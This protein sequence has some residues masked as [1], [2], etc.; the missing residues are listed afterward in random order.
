MN[1]PKKNFIYNLIYQVLVLIIPLITAP[2]LARVVG[3]KG[4]GTYSYTYSIVYYFMLLTL[5]GVNNYGN[6]SI[7]KVRDNKKKLSKTFW[8]I[9][10]FQLLMGIIML[11]A[12]IGYICLFDI[13]YKNIAILQTL[14]VLSAILD[15]NWFFF[16]MEEF[17]KTITRNTFVKVGNILLIFLLVKGKNDL[18]K[19]TLIMSGMTCLSQVI[20]WGFLRKQII[21]V[22]VKK[23]DIIKHIKPNLILFIPVVAVSLYKMMDKVMLGSMTSV[24][25][26]GY[27][28]NAEKIINMPMTLITAL[29]TVML[30]RISNII[31]KGELNK[32]G[33]YIEKSI[34]FV[35]FMS[36]AMCFG[37]MGISY[38]FA[39]FY[40]GNEFQKTGIL[41]MMLALTLPF[42]AFANVLRTQYLIPKEKDK[43]YII[44]VSL[45][46]ITNLV[47]NSIFISKLQSVGACIG[48][49][50]AEVSVMLYQTFAVRKELPVGK[51]IK[52]VFPFFVKGIIML[53]FIY[54]FNSFNM[55]PII[56]LVLQILIG[57]SIYCILNIKYIFSVID[58]N[59]I[60]IKLGIKKK[61]YILDDIDNDGTM[62][63]VT[64]PDDV[65]DTPILDKDLIPEEVYR[66]RE[67]LSR[68]IR[69]DS[70]YIRYI[71]FNYR[72]DFDIV[73]LILEETKIYSYVFH[74]E[75]YLRNNKYPTILSN[76]HTFVKYVI[77]KDFNNIFYVDTRCMS[78][79]E[80]RGLINYTFRKVYYLR[81]DD[82]GINFNI[83][84]F[85][86]SDIMNDSYFQECLKY[87]N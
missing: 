29:G 25:E 70:S 78:D 2:Y 63:V 57:G 87:L 62:D 8:S 74:N 15:I 75:D 27:Y 73:D 59:K 13:R 23:K 65:I 31:A 44:S 53:L 66:D 36:F 4:V 43:V 30:P 83:N 12:Y 10:L 58:L 48:T 76:N 33:K 56:R 18:W 42:L 82:R 51:Y 68:A 24:K 19:Y 40:F 72:Y 3:A 26:V 38:H 5:L 17:K 21:F 11:I 6:R 9:Y 84:K 52:E 47:L 85:S 49:I 20:L 77:D 35:M 55:S 69:N 64:I 50:A 45:G 46:A 79:E 34:K 81:E 41:M 80:V 60:L 7:A 1:N 22:K 32:V 61:K 14:F 39:P 71:D 16:G 54:P 67:S 37:L 86:Y 28:E